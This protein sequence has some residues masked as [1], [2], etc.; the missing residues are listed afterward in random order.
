VPTESPPKASI[1]VVNFN[2]V[3]LLEKCLRSLDA[4]STQDF[5]TIVVDNGSV[6]GSVEM[7]ENRFPQVRVIQNPD[8]FGFCRA[9]NQGFQAARG[10]YFLVLNNDAEAH[11]DWVKSL[12]E[13]ADANPEA[14]MVASK[15]YVAGSQQKIDK[16][17]HLIYWDGQNRGRGAGEQDF[18]QYD[19]EEI[20]WPDGCAALYRA[21]MIQETG[22]FDE[23]FFAYADDAELG[24]RGRLLGWKA[25]LAKRAVVYHHRGATLGKYNPERI[26]L[27]ERNRLWL[28]WKHFPWWLVLLNPVFFGLRTLGALF[29][30]ARGEG[31]ATHFHGIRAKLELAGALL[32]ANAKAWKGF[33]RMWSKRRSFRRVRRWNDWQ[34]LLLL[35]KF[36]I[37]LRELSRQKA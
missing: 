25:V 11:T 10:A 22:G 5:E 29:W 35:R 30:S 32:R 31:E 8:N 9:N 26:A 17:G 3:N 34:M 12:V 27:I 15:I 6:D 33:P 23:D 2:R 36:Q 7:L 19:E 20:L 24:L 1:I 18:G 28:V 14:G 37:S 21:Q 4:Q 13:C 16:I